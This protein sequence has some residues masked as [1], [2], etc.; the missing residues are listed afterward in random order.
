MFPAVPLIE[1]EQKCPLPLAAL[2]CRKVLSAT[3]HFLST[4]PLAEKY[5]GINPYIYCAGDPVN[6]LDPNGEFIDTILDV[7]SI[8]VDIKDIATSIKASDVKG[9]L[10][11]GATLVYDVVAA[12]IPGVPAVGFAKSAVK[13]ADKAVDAAKASG[14]Y[15][16]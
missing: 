1:S 8:G 14:K 12:A 2:R 10:V 16:S 6:S 5:F 9:A 13:T 11:S 7:Y 4:D 3:G 15:G